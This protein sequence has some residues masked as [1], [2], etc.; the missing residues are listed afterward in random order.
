MAT[1][2]SNGKRRTVRARARD[3]QFLASQ[4]GTN[5]EDQF[6]T[7]QR[8]YSDGVPITW[9]NKH[10]FL[11]SVKLMK[12]SGELTKEGEFLETQGWVPPGRVGTRI[13]A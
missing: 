2:F 8:L 11:G 3:E 7:V 10:A 1:L 6:A 13:P 5:A 9:K 4:R 12:R